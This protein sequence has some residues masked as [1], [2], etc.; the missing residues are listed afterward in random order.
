MSEELKRLRE[1]IDKTDQALLQLFAERLA[2]VAEVGELKSQQ[3]L[4]VYVP[5]REASLL[6]ARREEAIKLGVPPDLIEDILRRVMRESYRSEN[7]KGFKK[8]N[9]VMRPIVVVGGAGKMGRLFVRALE[10][11]DYDVRILEKDDWKHAA[12]SLADAGMVIISVPIET[13]NRVI[14]ALPKLPDDCIL[15]DLTSVKQQPMAAMLAIHDGPVLGLHPMFGPDCGSFAKQAVVCCNGR[16]PEAYQWFLAQ[17]RVWGA[18]LHM[19]TPEQH[20]KHMGLIQ[21]LR[22]FAT[23]TYGLYICKENIQLDD[24]LSLSSP[25][26]RLELV[27][28]GRLF[29]Q[30]PDLY[31]DIIMYSEANLALIKRY[32]TCFIDA[33]K[34]LE[35]GDKTAFVSAFSQVS[36]W[37]GK[38]ADD[39]MLESQHLLSSA[40]DNR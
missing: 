34:L 3:G 22:H 24:L 15:L 23:F 12:D 25:I 28:V 31:A 2:L 35:Q 6:A 20:D 36:E 39:F 30:D 16:N 37:F 4:P 21:A 9:P 1:K 38:H 27:M 26:Y 5:E 29:A 40:Q 14:A 11:S 19:T 33:I 32:N 8:L 17:I 10:L 18:K 7:D 13:T